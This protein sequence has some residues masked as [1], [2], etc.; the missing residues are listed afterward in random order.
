[1]DNLYVVYTS[2]GSI[3]VLFLLTKIM[4]NKQMSELSM[5]DYITGITIGS[6]AAEMAT[7]LE[8]FE[9]PLIAMLIYGLAAA[10]ISIASYKSIVIRRVV[11]GKPVVLYDNGKLYNKNLK[12]S[13]I[14]VN[15]FLALCRSNGFFDLSN[16]ETAI[17]ETNGKISFLPLS[18]QRPVNPGDLKLNPQ[19]EKT[20]A[21][22][23]IDGK[24]M[25]TN[26]K[27]TGKDEN[28]LNIQ[29]KS[30]GISNVKDAF[31]VTC[32]SDHQ[33]KIYSK[34]ETEYKRDIFE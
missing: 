34:I 16:I 1:M 15:E 19:Q 4:G 17:L 5:F 22:V 12:K 26:L 7:A 6:I 29:M 25:H 21:N 8:K 28:W 30:Q 9:K 3:I 27:N 32:D 13:K 14:D 18:T 33:I 24:I 20:V 11:T 2:L 23:V 10:F 31:L